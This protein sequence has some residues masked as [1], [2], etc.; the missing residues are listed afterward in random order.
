MQKCVTRMLDECKKKRIEVAIIETARSYAVQLAYY[1]QGREPL[2]VVNECRKTAGLYLISEQ[3]NKRKVTN[4]DGIKNRSNHQVRED[5]Y[6]HAV[7]IAPVKNGSIWWNA[8][9]SLWVE[10]GTIGE[11]CGLDWCA[12][13]Y[14]ATWGKGWDNPHFEMGA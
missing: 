5:G 8:Q 9:Q 1:M 7:D 4:C 13:G 12:G 6:G 10:I 14:G 2:A 3:E 11:E